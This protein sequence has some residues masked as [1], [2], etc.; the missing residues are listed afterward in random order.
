MHDLIARVS[1]TP[2]T[3]LALDDALGDNGDVE[4]TRLPED[5]VRAL[6]LLIALLLVGCHSGS[7]SSDTAR[8]SRVAPMDSATAHRICDS[9]DSVVAGTRE[10]VLRDQGVRP[11][12]RVR[13]IVP[14]RP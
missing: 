3:L 7:R 12:P 1:R 14:P 5:I 6:P 11:Q 13:P 9:P 10:C 4:H 8:G 2:E